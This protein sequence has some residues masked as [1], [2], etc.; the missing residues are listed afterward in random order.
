MAAT[1]LAPAGQEALIPVEGLTGP[2][3]VVHCA[4][5][6][7]F[8]RTLPDASVA[9]VVTDPPYELGFLG[10]TWDASGIAYSVELWAECLRV[11]KPGG[12]LAAFGATRTYHR[13]AVAVDEAGFE[14]RDSLHWLYGTGFPKGQDVGKLIDRR[15]DDHPARLR[16]TR[17]FAA[18][19]DAAGWTNPQIDAL[20]GYNG[21]AQ[22]WTTQCST[23]SVP[24][25][26]QWQRLKAGMGFDV[27]A[28]LEDLVHELNGRKNAPG[29]AWD[30][31]EVIGKGHRIRAGSGVFPQLQSDTFDVTAPATAEAVRWDGWN[32][33]LKPAHEPIVMARKPLDGTVATNV[34]AHGTGALH[35]AV[36]KTPPDDPEG[37]WPTN[38]LLT[39]S[40]AVEGG[41]VVDG[42]TDGCAEGCPV[43]ELDTQSGLLTSGANPRRRNADK[44][45]DV[46]GDFKGQTA[47]QPARGADSGG[48]SRFYPAFRYQAK[49]PSKERPRLPDGT[50]HPTVKPV[51]LMR[52]LV[53]LVTPPG[54]LV[55]DPF[56][57][58]GTT[59]E[60]ARLEGFPSIGI[61]QKAEYAELCRLRLRRDL[62]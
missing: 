7:D 14:I 8:L 9:A 3:P 42:C 32:T 33:A 5:A 20:F 57:G 58:S 47:C 36:C 56:A 27:P 29:E 59:L 53:R 15:R 28:G 21:M 60:A 62:E 48:A 22:H 6:L 31:R 51:A 34:L 11:L 30:D 44:F 52:W 26:E 17:E 4:E 49:A 43:A 45:R 55:L 50:V 19:R 2:E 38:I 54:G 46:Y 61:E 39:H 23:A 37:R 10:K 13:M 41:W 35:T 18:V 24:T 40:A 25:V 12:H 16:F 1:D